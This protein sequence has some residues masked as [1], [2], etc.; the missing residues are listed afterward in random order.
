MVG[1]RGRDG[2]TPRAIECVRLFVASVQPASLFNVI[3][4][5]RMKDLLCFVLVQR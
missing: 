2:D 3:Q 5:A 4:L 1:E